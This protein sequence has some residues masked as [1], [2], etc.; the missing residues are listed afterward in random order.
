MIQ[1]ISSDTLPVS[2]AC[3]STGSAAER[4]LAPA[5]PDD[6]ERLGEEI[7]E[8]ATELHTATYRLLVRLREFDAREGWN[9]FLSCAHWLSWRTGIDLGAGREKVRV[10]RALAQLPLLSGAMERGEVSYS[11]VRALTRIAT[12]ANESQLLEFAR[13]GT[14]WQVERV[15]RVWRRTDRLAEAEAESARHESRYLSVRVDDD[16]S[17]VVRGRLD[18]EVGALLQAALDRAA[19]AL[20]AGEREATLPEESERESTLTE[21]PGPETGDVEDGA[22]V[23]EAPATATSAAGASPAQR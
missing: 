9:G 20:V 22:E 11:K 6:L 7:A 3:A 1:F 2:P 13:S 12:P 16:G 21:G 8:L 18:P 4:S 14:A 5:A 19:M 10:A 17:Y 23:P 15:V